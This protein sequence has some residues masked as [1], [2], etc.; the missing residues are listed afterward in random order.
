[1]SRSSHK[2]KRQTESSTQQCSLMQLIILS[3]A[4][5]VWDLNVALCEKLNLVMLICIIHG[6]GWGIIFSVPVLTFASHCIKVYSSY[7]TV[8]VRHF[9]PVQSSI[10]IESNTCIVRVKAD[11]RLKMLQKC[12]SYS[13]DR[14]SNTRLPKWNEMC[15]FV[16]LFRKNKPKQ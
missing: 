8:L 16:L 3:S 13:G 11:H 1:M 4:L 12:F 10:K 5:Q 2:P 7:W 14:L 15:L 6:E 9:N